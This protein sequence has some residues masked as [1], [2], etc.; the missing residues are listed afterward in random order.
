MVET[1]VG[2]RD[3]LAR[4]LLAAVLTVMS[5]RTLKSGKRKIGLLTGVI[6]LVLGFTAT[7]Q[8]CGVNKALDIDTTDE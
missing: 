6:A 7:T 8:V 5:I 4:V 2:G 3:R 1:N